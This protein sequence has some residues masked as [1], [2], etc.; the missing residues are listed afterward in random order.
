MTRN[1]DLFELRM[2]SDGNL[3][4]VQLPITS[5][6][7]SETS[8]SNARLLIGDDCGFVI[9]NA[10]MQPIKNYNTQHADVPCRLVMQTDGN[11]VLYSK[12]NSV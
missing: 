2:Q 7:S 9:Y 11:L 5:I 4:L 3:N 12:S 6:W 8:G 10:Q 1:S